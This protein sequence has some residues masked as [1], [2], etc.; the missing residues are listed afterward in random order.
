[1]R[2]ER[3]YPLLATPEG[4]W[5]PRGRALGNAFPPV[6]NA[7]GQLA[8]PLPSWQRA[9][10]SWRR[11]GS[12]ASRGHARLVSQGAEVGTIRRFAH[13]NERH[14]LSPADWAG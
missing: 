13:R 6:G 3:P 4:Q 2:L 9:C 8:T 10:P 11:L 5:A 14:A 7:S 1:M 12:A